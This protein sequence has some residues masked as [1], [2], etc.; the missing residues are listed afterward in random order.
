MAIYVFPVEFT[1]GIVDVVGNPVCL[2][3]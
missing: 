1:Y 2:S 3:I